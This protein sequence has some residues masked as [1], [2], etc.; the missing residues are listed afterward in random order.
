MARKTKSK[1]T[2]L[3]PP[4]LVELEDEIPLETYVD[5][6]ISDLESLNLESEDI[7]ADSDPE[8]TEE[9]EE[10]KLGIRQVVS[11]CVLG[12]FS[13]ILFFLVTFPLNETVR[14][15]LYGISRDSGIVIDA[16]EIDFSVI[17]DKSFESIVVQFPSGLFLKSDELHINTSLLALWNSKLDGSLVANFLRAEVTD[18][19][20]FWKE[21]RIVSKLG[22]LEDR[23]SKWIGEIELDWKDGKINDSADYPLIGSLK[24]REFKRGSLLLKIRSG[25]ATVEKGNI[26]SSIAKIS[27]TGSIRLLD[28]LAQS[29]L[30]LKIC[31]L[32]TEAFNAERP[33]LAGMLTMLPQENGKV[34]IPLRGSLQNPKP[35]LP[36]LSPTGPR[37]QD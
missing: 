32:P 11:L 6:E 3:N 25:K 5:D 10:K 16:K 26:D 8:L 19:S 37:E 29:Q 33:D 21:L 18:L 17:G 20:L 14:S 22:S 28:Q 23:P 36:S 9:T 15:I 4:E 12:F 34:C 24:G 27:I 35:E 7:Q 31:A 1:T 13:F 30:D 2:E